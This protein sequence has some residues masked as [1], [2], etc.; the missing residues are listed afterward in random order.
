MYS[1]HKQYF[2]IYTAWPTVHLH[3]YGQGIYWNLQLYLTLSTSPT[4]SLLFQTC[5]SIIHSQVF[6]VVS[7]LHSAALRVIEFIP[8]AEVKLS[9]LVHYTRN[10]VLNVLMRKHILYVCTA[11]PL[12]NCRLFSTLHIFEFYRMY[13]IWYLDTH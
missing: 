12:I 2:E 5:Y 3:T 13:S 7:F 8:T 10:T 11:V 4:S 6:K 1:M 9:T